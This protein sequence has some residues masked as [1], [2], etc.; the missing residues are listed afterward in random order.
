MRTNRIGLDLAETRE[1]LRLFERESLLDAP[2]SAEADP[3][4]TLDD[5]MTVVEALCP[6]WPQRKALIAGSRMSL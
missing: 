2:A 1:Y 3:F 4:R 6:V 5:L